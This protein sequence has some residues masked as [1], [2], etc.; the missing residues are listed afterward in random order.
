MFQ[1]PRA[2][3]TIDHDGLWFASRHRLA[4]MDAKGR[5]DAGTNEE[6]ILGLLC[7]AYRQHVKVLGRDGPELYP[8]FHGAPPC[9]HSSIS[10]ACRASP[11]A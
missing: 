4:R 5:L 8:A 3:L 11:I 6:R 9:P 7:L 1:I 2:T 10:R